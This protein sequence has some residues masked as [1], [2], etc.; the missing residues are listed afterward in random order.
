[1][2]THEPNVTVLTPGDRDDTPRPL[3]PGDRLAGRYRLDGLRG[4][5][6]IA[7]VY[8]ATDET[9]GLPCAVKMLHAELGARAEMRELFAKEARV[10]EVIGPCEHI[11]D[12]LDAGVDGATNVPFIVMELLE[13]ET[14]EEALTRGPLPRAEADRLLREL[15]SALDRAHAAGV[16]HRDLKPS[17]LFLA[18]RS[19]GPPLLKV[20]DFGIAKLVEAGAVR[21]AT[22]TGTPAYTAPEQLGGTTRTLAAK[23]GIVIARG[24]SPAT[25]VWA[26]GLIAYEVYTGEPPGHYRRFETLAEL[27]MTIAFEELA[28]ASER[29]GARG[30]RLP[31]D[32]DG[33]FARCLRK[34]AA[35]R[36]PSAGE[37]VR[38]LLGRTPDGG[39][40]STPG[41]ARSPL[42]TVKAYP[43]ATPSAEPRS[44]DT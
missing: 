20:M 39:T 16:V 44:L 43:T 27:P 42:A 40:E 3:A 19:D 32:F 11:V 14:L 13:G 24:V 21:T 35:E 25:D 15:G 37:A 6:G 9:T 28:T 29:A 10:G 2:P 23:Q 5:G 12:V 17:N 31:A 8:R 4:E 22:P 26:L 36:W 33:W 41:D 38:A 34:D 7:A 18:R 30:H 1:M